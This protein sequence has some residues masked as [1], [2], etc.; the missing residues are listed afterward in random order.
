MKTVF[1][2][3]VV[4]SRETGQRIS[5]SFSLVVPTPLVGEELYTEMGFFVPT[6]LADRNI[7][8]REM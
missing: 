2:S 8:R 1:S 5:H 4:F 6:I 3:V 7:H